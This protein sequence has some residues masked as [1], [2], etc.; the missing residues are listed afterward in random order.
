MHLT[1]ELRGEGG[2]REGALSVTRMREGGGGRR[3]TGNQEA[4]GVGCETL[5]PQGGRCV[6][7]CV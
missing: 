7:V 2:G 3:G 1:V 6:C 5:G 4:W